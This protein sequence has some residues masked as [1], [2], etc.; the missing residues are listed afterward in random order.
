MQSNVGLL[1][2]KIVLRKVRENS[3]G[4][5][6][7]VRKRRKEMLGEFLLFRDYITQHYLFPFKAAFIS[8]WALP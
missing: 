8:L 2:T 1:S 5:R 4:P 6:L 7:T 3:K